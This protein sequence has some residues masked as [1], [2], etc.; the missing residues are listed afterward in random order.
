MVPQNLPV[1]KGPGLRTRN[2]TCNL[3]L[4]EDRVGVSRGKFELT[5]M[6]SL[7]ITLS[8]KVMHTLWDWISFALVDLQHATLNIEVS[9]NERPPILHEWLGGQMKGRR[10]VERGTPF[11]VNQHT[12]KFTAREIRAFTSRKGCRWAGRCA[13]RATTGRLG[14]P[15]C[16]RTGREPARGWCPAS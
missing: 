8:L 4:V 3:Q 12:R 15:A 16:G 7:F 14:R 11:I 2:R 1:L 10:L 13:L 9:R 6:L 5:G